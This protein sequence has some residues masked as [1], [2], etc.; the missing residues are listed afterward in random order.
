[1]QLDMVQTEFLCFQQDV[2]AA[3]VDEDPDPVALFR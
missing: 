1:M 2:F 3:F